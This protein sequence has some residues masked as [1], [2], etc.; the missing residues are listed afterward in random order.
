MEG[1]WMVGS[2]LLG[3][4]Y[5]TQQHITQQHPEHNLCTTLGSLYNTLHTAAA[6]WR[7]QPP[8]GL[9]LQA[10]GE[11]LEATLHS[12][13]QHVVQIDKITTPLSL[14]KLQAHL[15]EVQSKYS[16]ESNAAVFSGVPCTGPVSNAHRRATG[17][18]TLLLQVHRLKIRGSLV[19]ST[20][21]DALVQC[22]VPCVV[23]HLQW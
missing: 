23:K 19:L 14:A 16:Q 15:E 20:L 11:A 5:N 2:V 9:Y 18:P 6:R 13:R 1:V 10:V 8:V 4:H 21:H 12:Y 22:S 7:T 17:T 3:G